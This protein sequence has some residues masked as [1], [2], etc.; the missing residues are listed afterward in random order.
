MWGGGILK[1]CIIISIIKLLNNQFLIIP[2][3]VHILK[4]PLPHINNLI[5]DYDFIN[6]LLVLTYRK[7]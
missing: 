2:I 1:I 6:I 3:L 4:I 5:I 7:S